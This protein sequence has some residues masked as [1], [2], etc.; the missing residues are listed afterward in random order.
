M[1][2][3]TNPGRSVGRP[4]RTL[5]AQVVRERFI[6]VVVVVADAAAAAALVRKPFN[7]EPA[8]ISGFRKRP[9]RLAVGR[10]HDIPLK[11]SFCQQ[12]FG[13]EDGTKRQLRHSRAEW[14]I[15]SFVSG[16]RVPGALGELIDVNTV[17]PEPRR[18][19]PPAA[20]PSRTARG[21]VQESPDGAS[22]PSASVPFG[23]RLGQ[24]RISQRCFA[25][26]S[27]STRRAR[28]ALPFSY[29]SHRFPP[30]DFRPVPSEPIPRNAPLLR[31]N[32]TASCPFQ[33][34]GPSPEPVSKLFFPL[35]SPSVEATLRRSATRLGGRCF[36]R[37][38][39]VVIISCAQAEQHAASTQR[40]LLAR[41]VE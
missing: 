17:E 11:D 9:L 6:V 14:L 23:L 34:G 3:G 25:F 33:D 24:V 4:G 13:K 21:L 40:R 8:K 27:T 16:S 18:C 12:R 30:L 29:W 36:R 39:L 22:V 10:R 37:S 31:E 7:P 35:P 2:G 15:Y 1:R 41:R 38:T 28:L 19:S 32:E 5:G 26:P 20:T